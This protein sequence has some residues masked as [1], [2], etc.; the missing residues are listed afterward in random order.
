MIEVVVAWERSGEERR[1][2]RRAGEGTE[3][4]R[5]GGMERGR[6]ETYL[7]LCNPPDSSQRQ[8]E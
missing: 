7:S 8:L 1:H 4:M 6:G 5:D 3:R 2:G